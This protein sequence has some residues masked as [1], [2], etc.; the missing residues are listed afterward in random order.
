M[1]PELILLV[2]PLWVRAFAFSLVT[3]APF[4]ALIGR[5]HG[6][7]E[8]PIPVARLVFAGAVGTCL[9]HPLLWFVW[10]RVI[11]D[12]AWYTVSGE[13]IV[14]AVEAI[15][16]FALARP[17][18]FSRAVAASFIANAASYGLGELVRFTGLLG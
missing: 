8:A 17:I 11:S 6:K 12:F 5:L 15:V 4:Y 16:L 7:G 14:A 9:T 10:P 18:P 13:L 1:R 3:E 2:L